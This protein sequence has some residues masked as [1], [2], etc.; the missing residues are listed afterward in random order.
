LAFLEYIHLCQVNGMMNSDKYVDV[1][2][3]KVIPDMRRAFPV[4]GGIFQRDLAQCL[5]SKKVKTVFRKYKLNML[6]WPG[7]SPNLNP[8]DHS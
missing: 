8:I 2:E 4:S 7:N 1:I 6:D 3:R 5:S